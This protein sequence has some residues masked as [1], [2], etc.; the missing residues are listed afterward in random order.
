MHSR[1]GK[2]PVR[3]PSLAY[4]Y[5]AILF[6]LAVAFVLRLF[7]VWSDIPFTYDVGILQHWGH[8]LFYNG[9]AAF[10]SDGA[11]SDYPPLYMYV[12]W[13]IGAVRDAFGF[14]PH[15]ISPRSNLVTFMPAILFDLAAGALVY[16]SC[17]YFGKDEGRTTLPNAFGVP[18]W[19]TAVYLWNPA[20]ILNS[21]IWGQVDAVHTFMMALA[22]F[23]L[24][25]NLA[26]PSIVPYLLF[27]LAVMVKPQSLI[28]A[29]IFL[30]SALHY[31]WALRG[32]D[33]WRINHK[34]LVT[35]GTLLLFAVATFAL[36]FAVSAPFAWT[37]TFPF[38]DFYYVV[39]QYIETFGQRPH[40]TINAYNFHFMVGGNWG[41]ITP[42]LA[43]VGYSSIVAVTL[44][45]FWLLL[46][47]FRASTLF[48]S[49]ALL[50]MT[51]FTFSVRMNE[52]YGFP[53]MLFLVLAYVALRYE[54]PAEKALHRGL[55]WIF[56]LFSLAHFANVADILLIGMR[57]G[58]R[59]FTVGVEGTVNVW[60]VGQ[61]VDEAAA[62]VAAVNMALVAAM[63]VMA[64]RLRKV[65]P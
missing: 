1:A 43:F 64:G 8:T 16:F 56:T 6:L 18:F 23:S 35:A 44:T 14:A 61:P 17:L 40:P 5:A 45:V 54:A 50:F 2:V 63:F 34:Q 48:F 24:A 12:L 47:K 53:A 3:T 65:S 59:L 13:A 29:P 32:G 31:V 58:Q 33:A 9:L 36:M 27:G 49:G 38:V 55:L 62:L 26:R 39:S 51:T 42:F 22:L 57:G 10:Y 60:L 7:G 15:Y 25:K 4:Y 21:S 19:L 11:F 37:G 28:V 30:C 52:R 41:S 46:G 20:V